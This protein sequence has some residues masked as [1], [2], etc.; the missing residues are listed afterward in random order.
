[1]KKMT[2]KVSV[3]K[4]ENII[5]LIKEVNKIAC[6]LQLDM[7]N[8]FVTVENVNESMIDTVIE[9]INS[10][11]ILLGVE[12]DNSDDSDI[13]DVEETIELS[14]QSESFSARKSATKTIE[15]QSEDDLIIKKIK[16]ENVYVENLLNKL[17]RTAYWT[18]FKLNVPEKEI[19][20]F[21][22]T[23]INEISMRYNNKNTIPLSIG[24][25]VDCNY[26]T[27]LGGEISGVH[28][29]AIVCNISENG[30]IYLVPIIKMQQNL[31][32]H[33]Y[34][35]LTVPNDVIYNTRDYANGIVLLDKGKYLHKA[36]INEVIGKTS[37]EFF[38]K[39]LY[40]LASTFDFINANI[41]EKQQ[42]SKNVITEDVF[43]KKASESVAIVKTNKNSGKLEEDLLEVIGFALNKLTPSKKAKEQIESF[44]IDI[45]MPIKEKMVKQ[46]FVIA[47]DIK[48]ITYENVINELHKANP[49]VNNN[50]IKVILK[51]NFNKW[52]EKYPELA[53]KCPKISF[54]SILKVFAK[55]LA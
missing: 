31:T 15:S 11:Y 42:E 50:S 29:P 52:L 3:K 48:K 30:M 12:I 8:G 5:D 20:E 40:Q 23:S 19:G 10:Y 1:M 2:F 38:E 24:D 32:S 49:M 51:E 46:S 16:F 45:G 4:E 17:L 26:G 54:M 47:C 34:L 33:S 18:M 55:R 28:K 7:E 22:W 43:S 39:V 13:T 35:T 41:T 27:H 44:L 53:K 14:N 6:R 36:R 9:L 25:V 21:I 37:S